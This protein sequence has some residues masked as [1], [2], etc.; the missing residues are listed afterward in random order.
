MCGEGGG[1]GDPSGEDEAVRVLFSLYQGSS[2]EGR[3]LY[4]NPEEYFR[5]SN[6]AAKKNNKKTD[7][8]IPIKDNV[9]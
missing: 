7:K 4:M 2:T 9:L 3:G 6:R 8:R 1:G 5:E